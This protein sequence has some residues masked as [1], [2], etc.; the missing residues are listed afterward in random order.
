[1]MAERGIEPF[2]CALVGY[3]AATCKRPVGKSWRVDETYVKANGQWKYLYRAV[4]KAGNTVD[5]LLRAHRDTAAARRHF[6]KAIEQNGEPETIT[7]DRSGANLAA[8]EA[9]NAE[10]LAPIK[11]WQNKYLNNVD[12]QDH[13]AIKRVIKPMM[14]FKDSAVRAS[15]CPA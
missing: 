6:E 15:S 7:V 9:L 12:E 1:M 14:G 3:Q 11:I 10:R 2:E 4:G 13:R 5:F 8:L